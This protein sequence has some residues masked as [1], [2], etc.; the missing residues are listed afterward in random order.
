[1]KYRGVLILVLFVGMMM[2]AV[3]LVRE[4]SVCPKQRVVYR[5]LPRTMNDRFDNPVPVSEVFEKLFTQPSPWIAGVN[6]VDE[7]RQ[8]KINKFF[9]S[10]M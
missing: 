4:K 9:I 10:Q 1:M 2:V 6:V 5:Y 3:E 7:K 8:E